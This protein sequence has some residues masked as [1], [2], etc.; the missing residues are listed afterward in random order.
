MVSHARR[1]L[2]IDGGGS[3]TLALVAAADGRV[4]GRGEAGPSNYQ[5]IGLDAALAAL[6]AAVAAALADAGCGPRDLIAACVGLA[7]V[8]RPADRERLAAWAAVHL[9]GVPVTVANDAQLVL[10]AGTPDG[11]GVTLICGTGSIA[12]GRRADGKMARAG[13]W[14]Y[15]LGDEG[16]GYAIGLAA[17]RAVMRAYDGRGPQTTL[18][19]SV[20]AEY[21]LSAASA[22][23]ARIYEHATTPAEIAALAAL[24]DT[25]AAAGDRV[26]CDILHDAGRELALA[27]EA[28]IRRLELTGAAPCA[29]AG[30]VIV[31]GRALRAAFMEAMNGLGFELAPLTLVHEPA[32]GAVRLALKK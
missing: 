12:Y 13:G 16:S 9:P 24:V 8:D 29:L 4:L 22:L 26:A 10:A 32:Q 23:V 27:A 25:A 28:V 11:W 2:G 14:G 17:L 30:G 20:L 18:T 31:K 5:V 3:K 6:E 19:G 15:L 21:R 1:V 7:G